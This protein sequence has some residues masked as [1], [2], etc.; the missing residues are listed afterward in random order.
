MSPTNP[1]APPISTSILSPTS[2]STLPATSPLQK[3]Q[4]HLPSLASTLSQPE[5]QTGTPYTGHC[6][7]GRL[8]YLI[9]IPAPLT[10]PSTNIEECDCSICTR[11]AYL[12]LR[13]LDGE[14][15]GG[16]QGV[17][18]LNEGSWESGRVSTQQR[19]TLLPNNTQKQQGKGP[20]IL[21]CNTNFFLSSEFPFSQH[22]LC[23]ANFQFL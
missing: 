13:V 7:C 11:N 1:S 5:Q 2:P 6:H 4:Q 10:D 16:C 20:Y 8:T 18:F 23:T 15:E 9:T 21:V 22:P 14:E 17:T 3:P 12:L 19:P